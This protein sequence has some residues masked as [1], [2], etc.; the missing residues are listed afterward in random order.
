MLLPG[1]DGQGALQIGESVRVS[2][3]N[4][5][6]PGSNGMEAAATSISIGIAAVVPVRGSDYRHLVD[7]ADKALYE[8]KAKGRNRSELIEL[9]DAAGP[10]GPR[11]VA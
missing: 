2:V 4:L 6:L 10:N 7:A 8:A 11:L 3:L 9:A 5:T 1:T